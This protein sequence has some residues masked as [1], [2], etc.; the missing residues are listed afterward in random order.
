MLRDYWR[1]L[2]ALYLRLRSSTTS[3]LLVGK[4]GE[5][6]ERRTDYVWWPDL[7][8]TGSTAWF[9]RAP[10]VAGFLELAALNATA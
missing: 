8:V 9:D 7:M 6:I 5:L 4:F 10:L 1:N 3:F 2:L